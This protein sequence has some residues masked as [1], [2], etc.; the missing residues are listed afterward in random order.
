ML[1]N[2]VL[3]MLNILTIETTLFC[4]FINNILI[5]ISYEVYKRK[6]IKKINSFLS[7]NQILYFLI[8]ILFFIIHATISLIT[9][10]VLIIIFLTVICSVIVY[11]SILTYLKDENYVIIFRRIKKLY[12][13]KILKKFD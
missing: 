2:V 10:N 3:A 9:N 1:S 5:F 13:E 6:K 4:S 12:F 11:A 7:K 8:S